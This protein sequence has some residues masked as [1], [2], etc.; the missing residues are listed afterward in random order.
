MHVRIEQVNP[1][2]GTGEDKM[3]IR[4][5]IYNQFYIS[6]IQVIVNA[7]LHP[8]PWPKSYVMVGVSL[9]FAYEKSAYDF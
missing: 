6:A 8:V 7:A 3:L 5:M 4:C 2:N 9:N 1:F